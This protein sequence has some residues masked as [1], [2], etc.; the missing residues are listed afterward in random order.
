MIIKLMIQILN[1]TIISEKVYFIFVMFIF[2]LHSSN[3]STRFDI[4]FID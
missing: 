4:Q 1:S 3:F 2:A